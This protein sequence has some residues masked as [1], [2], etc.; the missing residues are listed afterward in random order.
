MEDF[1][2]LRDLILLLEENESPQESNQ[3]QKSIHPAPVPYTMGP[4]EPIP[5]TKKFKLK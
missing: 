3:S 1:R 5:T 4:T 2:V